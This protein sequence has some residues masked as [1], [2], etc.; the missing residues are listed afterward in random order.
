M[1]AYVTLCIPLRWI[2]T[3]PICANQWCR[4]TPPIQ[5]SVTRWL[6]RETYSG[7]WELRML[8]GTVNL[9]WELTAMLTA[10]VSNVTDKL[11]LEVKGTDKLFLRTW[12]L[13]ERPPLRVSAC[14]VSNIYFRCLFKSQ[15]GGM[16]QLL[17]SSC[18]SLLEIQDYFLEFSCSS[19]FYCRCHGW[20]G[21]PHSTGKFFI[22]YGV[23]S[24]WDY[25]TIDSKEEVLIQ[26]FRYRE[27]LSTAVISVGWQAWHYSQVKGVNNNTN[28]I[29]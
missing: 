1:S 14:N 15:K 4:G 21:S 13:K 11:P 5:K 8:D 2:G 6:R 7:Y 25:F 24:R 16:Y 10:G 22:S 28:R 19:L 12:R 17:S 3:V 29:D 23:W 26:L 18:L 27:T 20:N 9:C